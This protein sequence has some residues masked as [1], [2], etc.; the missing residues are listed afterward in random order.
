MIEFGSL[1]KAAF[2]GK[3]NDGSISRVQVFYLVRFGEK[4]YGTTWYT[5]LEYPKN[6]GVI[7]TKDCLVMG[8]QPPQV[9]SSLDKNRFKITLVD[10]NN[11]LNSELESLVGAP[12]HVYLGAA[13]PDTGQPILDEKEIFNMYTGSID[14]ISVQ[15]DTNEFGSQTIT[16]ELTNPFHNL[17][18]KKTFYSTRKELRER[19]RND[20]AFDQVY[21][22]STNIMLRW[23]KYFGT[24]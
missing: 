13:D 3:K 6:S 21:T 14:G 17:D 5:N 1:L 18:K 12:A 23:G 22:G 11:L 9:D 19:A 15:Y 16:A 20:S 7:Y 8:V 10:N 4:L 24:K 2:T